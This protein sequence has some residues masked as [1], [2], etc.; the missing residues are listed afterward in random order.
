[1]KCATNTVLT[2][3]LAVLVLAGVVFALQ[4]IFRQRELRNMQSQTFACQS[5]MQRVGALLNEAAQY[6]KTHAD[7]N[8]MLQ[9]FEGKPTA[10]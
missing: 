2:V 1:M 6:G 9:P 3:V 10:R 8:P 4:T 7:I 5:N